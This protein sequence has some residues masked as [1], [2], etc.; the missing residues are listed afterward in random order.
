VAIAESEVP[1]LIGGETGTGKELIARAIHRASG[2]RGA[3]IAVNCGAMPDTL[4]ESELFGHV[5]GAFS[6]ASTERAGHF[7]SA[8][9][10]T[11]LLDE[12]GDL[13]LP[14]QPALL[15]VL[16]ESEVVPVGASKPISIDVRVVAAT[17]RGLDEQVEAKEFRADL[18]TR[19]A[20][21]RFELLPL[22]ERREDMGLII[23]ALL[24]R[25]AGDRL[26]QISLSIPAARVLMSARWPGNVRELE[27]CLQASSA[28]AKDGR[29]DVEHLPESVRAP[30]V[31]PAV[32]SELST[33]DEQL[34]EEVVAALREHQGNVSAAAREL[35]K[36]RQQIQRWIKWFNLD[37]ASYR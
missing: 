23:S 7:R 33:S 6:G 19:L 14:T 12:I 4:V 26:A 32:A 28:L 21:Y 29:I 16:Q 3:M 8:D 37:P 9:N 13:P 5:K 36:A 25:I 1:V 24:E 22:R 30:A 10:G 35:G 34:R 31:E 15:R 27:R 17:H 11:I 20:G 2:R 18:L